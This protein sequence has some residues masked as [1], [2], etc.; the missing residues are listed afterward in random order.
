MVAKKAKFTVY[1]AQFTV[2]LG[3]GVGWK[4]HMGG[5]A[6]NVEIPSYRV[7]GS[8]IAQK[9]VIW[10]LNV[11]LIR[12]LYFLWYADLSWKVDTTKNA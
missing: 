1:F 4:R 3:E 6:E 12:E 7:E 10:Y 2:D 9:I 8:K 11:P 5:V